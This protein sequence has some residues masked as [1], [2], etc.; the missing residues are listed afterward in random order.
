MLESGKPDFPFCLGWANHT[1]SRKTWTKYKQ[2]GSQLL[3]EQTYPGDEDIVAH[4]Y[5]VLPAFKDHRYITVDGKPLFLIWSPLSMPDAAHFMSMWKKLAVEN[6]LSGIHF[7]GLQGG[8]LKGYRKTLDL[9]FDAMNWENF[10]SAEMKAS[11]LRTFIFPKIQRFYS[12]RFLLKKYHYR[13]I[14]KYFFTIIKYSTNFCISTIT[15]SCF[16]FSLR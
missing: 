16:K 12:S 5:N 3:V 2:N 6:G 9:G 1:W 13:D 11:W 15:C 14:I 8:P 7:V 4:F 10:Y